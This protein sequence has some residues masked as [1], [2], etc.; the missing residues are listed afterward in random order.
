[1]VLI[2]S[3]SRNI[4]PM[5]SSSSKDSYFNEQNQE[6]CI[7]WID[8]GGGKCSSRTLIVN[9]GVNHQLLLLK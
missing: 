5:W 3:F 2:S 7:C 6:E 8:K 9:A 1:M 4:A